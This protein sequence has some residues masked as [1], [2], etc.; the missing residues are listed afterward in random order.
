MLEL[1]YRNAFKEVYEILKY[2]DIEC[3][4]RNLFK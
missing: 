4:R 2:T 1:K 3:T